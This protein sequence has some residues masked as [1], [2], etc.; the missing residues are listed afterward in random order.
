VLLHLQ[1][2]HFSAP[3]QGSKKT[4]AELLS[5]KHLDP[6]VL[7]HGSSGQAKLEDVLAKYGVN[8]LN[9]D[10]GQTTKGRRSVNSAGGMRMSGEQLVF[11]LRS[12]IKVD[13]ERFP[14][15]KLPT[16]LPAEKDW[17]Q[18]VTQIKNGGK[19]AYRRFR[20]DRRTPQDDHLE[21][22]YGDVGHS[23]P[24]LVVA[25]VPVPSKAPGR[26]RG[27]GDKGQRSE[28]I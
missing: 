1:I 12:G 28:A 14:G 27:K 10:E 19:E 17:R 15:R 5:D 20:V 8:E 16:R 21:D 11:P 3:P 24:S 22:E 18:F 25:P 2:L 4:V 13:E 9:L 23:S 6:Q 26:G 7:D